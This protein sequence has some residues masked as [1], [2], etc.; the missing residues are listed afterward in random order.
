MLSLPSV[1]WFVLLLVVPHSTAQS[2]LELMMCSRL[3]LNMGQSLNLSLPSFGITEV[4]H[5]I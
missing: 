4:S 1:F 3:A 5:H 2:S